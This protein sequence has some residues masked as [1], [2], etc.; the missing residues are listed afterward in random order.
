MFVGSSRKDL[1]RFPAKVK[2]RIGYALNEVQEGG[3]PLAA[4]ALKGFGGRTV[5]ELVDDFDSN[6][7]RAVYTVR[8]A[9]VVYVLHAFQKK[10]KKGIAT[11]SEDIDLVKSR[12][13][14]AELHYRERI[15]SG[16]RKP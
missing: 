14:D 11:P 16:G 5:L 3:E 2:N 8:F 13:R 9:G 15:E 6:T 12:L 7:Y 4:K 10:A 1:K